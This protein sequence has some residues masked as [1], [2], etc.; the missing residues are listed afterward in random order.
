M[1]INKLFNSLAIKVNLSFLE[2][3]PIYTIDTK[4]KLIVIMRIFRYEIVLYYNLIVN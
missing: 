4:I 3:F 2:I 1:Q